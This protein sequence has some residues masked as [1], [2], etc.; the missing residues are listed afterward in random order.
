M[1]KLFLIIFILIPISIFAQEVKDSLEINDDFI[2]E[3]FENYLFFEPLDDLYP[4][5]DDPITS[6]TTST[7]TFNQ[8]LTISEK[9]TIQ[10]NVVIK[11]G[12]LFVEG[13]SIGDALVLK[14]DIHIENNGVITGDATT[15]RGEIFEDGFVGGIIR[16]NRGITNLTKSQKNIPRKFIF[17]PQNWFPEHYLT[18]EGSF[19]FNRV[20]Q[21]A[22]GFTKTKNLNS[23]NIKPLSA[24]YLVNYSFG[25]HKWEGE[26]GLSRNI[27]LQNSFLQLSAEYHSL[28]ST[29]D[30]WL[31][32]TED[33]SLSTLFSKDDYMDYF[34]KEGASL[35][36]DF[37]FAE[38]Q[39]RFFVG[40]SYL[41]DKYTSLNKTTNWS[42]FG[43]NLYRENYLI[44][45]GQINSLIFSAGYSSIKNNN[46][47]SSGWNI[48]V[49]NEIG[50]I[51]KNQIYKF[52]R[53]II[54]IRRLQSISE[55][56]QLR[57]RL[58]FGILNG[59]TIQ[60]K[61]LFLGGFNSLPAYSYKEFEGSR[62][63]LINAE[64]F[65][66]GDLIDMVMPWINNLNLILLANVGEIHYY[67]KSVSDPTKEIINSFLNKNNKM[68]DAGIA[69]SWKDRDSRLS[70]LWRTDKK[71]AGRVSL[72]LS[73]PF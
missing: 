4:L 40:S 69:F 16:E 67:E 73:Y 51:G 27:K 52:D 68:S 44:D 65:I 8:S 29:D 23:Q 64:Y 34:Y 12:N 42:L 3:D 66:K 71:S 21:V 22:I 50:G 20:E 13:T 15:L 1:K 33:N 56:D 38:S 48:F 55:N 5:L 59:D 39:N 37:H 58:R 62:M 72:Q 28:V 11:K 17:T 35:S 9:D 30:Q 19:R 41:N 45:E 26:F 53:T 24:H 25:L 18:K 36:L 49:T 2:F 46:Y 70:C 31:I 10:G 60:Q 54:D 63:I 14:G 7:Q 43:K 57:I 6:I 47:T 61:K 32:T